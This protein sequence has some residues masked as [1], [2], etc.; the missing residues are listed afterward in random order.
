M[1]I[2]ANKLNLALSALGVALSVVLSGCMSMQ[3]QTTLEAIQVAGGNQ[4]YVEAYIEY[5][6]PNA[7]WA[8]PASFILHI[9]AKDTAAAQVAMTPNWLFPM[10]N[11]KDRAL[12]SERTISGEVAREHM[13]RLVTAIQAGDTEFSGCLYPIRVRL[14]RADGA[15]VEKHGCRG[16]VGW[17]KASSEVVDQFIT[18][19]VYGSGKAGLR[20]L[21]AQPSSLE[22]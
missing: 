15:I 13:A 18:A 14:I 20:T 8:G 12:A 4:P 1:K 21:A 6:G 19:S 5:P 16:P 2:V 7:K 11:P 10:S 22:K 3:S 9:T 17:A